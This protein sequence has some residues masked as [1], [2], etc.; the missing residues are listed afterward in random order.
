MSVHRLQVTLDHSSVTN[1][2]VKIIMN[3]G[4]RVQLTQPLTEKPLSSEA[5]YIQHFVW[6][7]KSIRTQSFIKTLAS[8]HYCAVPTFSSSDG[9]E[10][11]VMETA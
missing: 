7:E 3:F 11:D 1:F 4:L 2:N 10:A 9:P 8:N 6:A 5:E